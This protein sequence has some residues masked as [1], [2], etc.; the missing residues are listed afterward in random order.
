M[1]KSIAL[2]EEHITDAHIALVEQ[3]CKSMDLPLQVT[4]SVVEERP[5]FIITVTS[6]S[7]WTLAEAFFLIGGAL[8]YPAFQPL[9]VPKNLMLAE[10]M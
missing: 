1:Q 8:P 9:V 4:K 6:A 7:H 3:I 10:M 2:P 5:A